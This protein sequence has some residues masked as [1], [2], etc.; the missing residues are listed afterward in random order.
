MQH[1]YFQTF[2]LI[3]CKCGFLY[4]LCIIVIDESNKH[5]FNLYRPADINACSFQ[6]SVLTK[7]REFPLSGIVLEML[8]WKKILGETVLNLNHMSTYSYLIICNTAKQFCLIVDTLNSS[9]YTSSGT[10]S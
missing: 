6:F 9:K 3:L 5:E 1:I 7:R 10:T 8:I 4:M 2:W